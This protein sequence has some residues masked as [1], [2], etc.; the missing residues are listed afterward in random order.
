MVEAA[1]DVYEVPFTYRKYFSPE[2]VSEM[3]NAFKGY[4]TDSSGSI[5]ANELKTAILSMGHSEVTDEQI[6]A[7]LQRVDKNMDGTVDWIEFLD[8]MQG[9]KSSGQ[10]FGQA[11]MNK[12]GAAGQQVATA[13]GGHHTYLDEEVS[14][15]ARC[16]NR[17]CKDDA[18]LAERLPIDPTNQDLFHACSDGMLLIHLINHIEQDAIDMRTVNT[19]SNLN[20]Y[21]VR[22]NLDQAFSVAKGMI[23]VIGVD[24]QTFLD[25]TPYLMLGILWQLVRILSMKTITLAECPEI[26]RLL[27]PNEE[28][29]DLQKLK[30]EQVLVRWLNFHLRAA[31]QEPVSNL[32]SDLADSKK[33]IYVLNQ[34][35]PAN[36]TLDA[37]EDGDNLSRAAKMIASSKAMGV[38]D[39]LGPEDLVKGNQKVNSV[40]VAAIFNTKS[41]L[42]ELTQEEFEAAGII[43]DDI[44]GA[45]EER[46][47]R[48]WI[49]SMQIENVLIDNLFEEIRDGLVIL[50]VCHRIDN[51]SVD[52]SKPKMAPKN[53]FDVS[54]NANL[55]EEAMR[56]LGVKMV[57]VGAQDIVDVHKKNILAMVWQLM[58]IHYLKIIGSK[59]DQDLLNWMNQ[60]LQPEQP[61]RQFND[62]Q[63]ADGR[64]LIKLTGSVE[65]RIINWDLVTPGTTDEEKQ[66][67]AKYAISIARKLGAIIF[68]VWDDIPRLNKKMILIFVCSIYDLKHNI[69]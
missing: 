43:D 4:D 67:N 60:V 57:G 1:Q 63:L 11:M 50:R 61:I 42:Q 7:M 40:F 41:G 31:G 53:L 32:G 46:A 66:M 58:R 34:L 13:S 15:I 65:P 19:G 36:C 24:A 6:Q 45:R 35:D 64:L 27:E 18:L 55:A 16:I 69:Q 54:H 30:A 62:P 23:K 51:A 9:I 33:L 5:D 52:W 48:L 59:T 68:M 56:F 3:I 8:M 21:K 12:A 37:L 44:E 22:E 47:I 49:N 29:A 26:Y 20:I 17:V 39:C 25:K 38:E 14:M 2:Q 10:N 28:L